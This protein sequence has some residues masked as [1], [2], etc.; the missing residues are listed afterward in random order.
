MAE[1]IQPLE[2]Q[3]IQITEQD[4][5]LSPPSQ[6]SRASSVESGGG[7]GGNS[8]EPSP[9]EESKA[10]PAAPKKKPPAPKPKEEP[11]LVDWSKKIDYRLAASASETF[12]REF[13]VNKT[14]REK[15]KIRQ[16]IIPAT[17]KYWFELKQR[18]TGMRDNLSNTIFAE[19]ISDAK[20]AGDFFAFA[21]D[22]FPLFGD[23][24]RACIVLQL[25]MAQI[26]LKVFQF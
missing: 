21:V 9:R 25:Y 6:Q 17:H 5:V 23:G 22:H 1:K 8:G 3:K 26:N 20:E 4:R 13:F 16:Q 10:K 7:S 2:P 12:R 11:K 14:V 15:K 24:F 18:L 19:N